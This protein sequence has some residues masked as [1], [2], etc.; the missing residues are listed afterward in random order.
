[1]YNVS[2]Q[3]SK[4]EK[5]IK[6]Y[7]T[8]VNYIFFYFENT[9]ILNKFETQI[10]N[11]KKGHNKTSIKKLVNVYLWIGLYYFPLRI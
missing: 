3:A 1:M 8:L 7:V 10:R 9:H 11:E 2:S 5:K 4:R 6:G